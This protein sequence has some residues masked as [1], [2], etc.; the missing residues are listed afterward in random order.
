M[1]A[2]HLSIRPWV[3]AIT[4]ESP[5]QNTTSIPRHYYICLR[6]FI[7]L[8]IKAGLKR[9]LLG[10]PAIS[11]GGILLPGWFLVPK[12]LCE[13]FSPA[14]P[15]HSLKFFI[16]LSWASIIYLCLQLGFVYWSAK[17]Q[18]DQR[19]TKWTDIF[20]GFSSYSSGEVTAHDMK[21]YKR[22]EVQFRSFLTSAIDG[23]RSAS[24]PGRLHSPEKS[25]GTNWRAGWKGP[26][27]GLS[28]Y[29]ENQECFLP[30]PFKFLIQ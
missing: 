5:L 24:C 26:R 9:L 18:L 27:D 22:A 30:R 29:M 2:R 17:V 16:M 11:V 14:T 15:F 6:K 23:K 1:P 8:C 28:S 20:G 12:A 7:I 13:L 10:N 19:L 3:L 25:P 21:A 4:E